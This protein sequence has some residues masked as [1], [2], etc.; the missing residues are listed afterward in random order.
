MSIYT[1][2][3][4]IIP[5]NNWMRLLPLYIPL[6]PE[7]TLLTCFNVDNMDDQL[8]VFFCRILLLVFAQTST[9]FEVKT[10]MSARIQ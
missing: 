8:H 6:K 5:D 2:I 3:L 4:D 10:W 9:A 1:E 7:G